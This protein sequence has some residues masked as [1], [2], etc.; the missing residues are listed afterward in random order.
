MSIS[1]SNQTTIAASPPRSRSADAPFLLMCRGEDERGSGFWTITG[2]DDAEDGDAVARALQAV[3]DPLP[4][5]CELVAN[6]A[7]ALAKWGAQASR[8]KTAQRERVGS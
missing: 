5:R 8:R 7:H 6:T 4:M 1:Q 2:V 3:A